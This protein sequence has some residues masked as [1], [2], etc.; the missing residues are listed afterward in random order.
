MLQR[1]GD[2]IVSDVLLTVSSAVTINTDASVLFLCHPS[3]FMLEFV[4]MPHNVNNFQEFDTRADWEMV[5]HF[6]NVIN[7]LG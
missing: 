6:F 7:Q 1:Q 2:I 4:G 5:F 3:H